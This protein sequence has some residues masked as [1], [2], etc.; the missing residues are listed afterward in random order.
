MQLV[1]DSIYL[2]WENKKI[3]CSLPV[4]GEETDFLTSNKDIA[5]K[6]LDQQCKRWYNDENK[7][8]ILEAFEKLFKTGDTRFMHQLSDEELAEFAEKPVQYFIP[9]RV[10][11]NDSITTPVRPVLDGS[12]GTRKR[13]DGTGGRCL[14]DYV[15]KGKIETLNLIRLVLI[16]S[17]G[18]FAVTGDLSQ[19]YYS[20]MLLPEQW[21]LQRFLWR[22]D[23]D[24]CNPVMEGII[25]ALIY[26]IK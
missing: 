6:V 13:K 24:P 23:L 21:N 26:G 17:I 22:Q 16:F 4:R 5:M 18:L 1:K 7:D 11:Y 3:V 19:F 9:W 14:N 10:V 12:T 15:V 8:S 2:D 20:F 25:G